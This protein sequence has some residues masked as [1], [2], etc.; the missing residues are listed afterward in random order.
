MISIDRFEEILSDLAEEIPQS[1]YEELNGGIVVEPGYLLHPEDRNGTLYV[2]GQYRIDPAMG[3]YIVMYYGSF[4]RAYRHLDEDELTEEMRKVLRH[5]FRHHVEGRAGVRDLEVW[6]AE[7]IAMYKER[8][9]GFLVILEQQKA[10]VLEPLNYAFERFLIRSADGVQVDAAG[11]VGQRPGAGLLNLL[12][13][14]VGVIPRENMQRCTDLTVYSVLDRHINHG[15][16]EINDR[17]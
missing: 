14:R 5:E 12:V 8:S 7:Q 2:M 13:K 3:K 15:S 9:G 17:V 1:F 16:A 4:K 11:Q 6:D 10:F